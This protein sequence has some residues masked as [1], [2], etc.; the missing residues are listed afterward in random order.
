MESYDRFPFPCRH[1]DVDPDQDIIDHV[2]AQFDMSRE[3]FLQLVG[4]DPELD[5]V[6]N[7]AKEI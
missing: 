2:Q 4:Y 3:Q 5:Q 1:H 7:K 6:L